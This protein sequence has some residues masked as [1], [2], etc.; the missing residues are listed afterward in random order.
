MIT[1]IREIVAHGSPAHQDE[2]VGYLQLRDYG[3]GKLPGVSTAIFRCLTENDNVEALAKR[4]DVVLL[5]I[6]A[7]FRNSTNAHRIFDEHVA[8]GDKSQ[9]NECAAT[10][11][12][13]FLGTDKNFLWRQILKGV[14]HADKNPPNLTLD[15]AATVMRLQHQG[16]GLHAAVGYVEIAVGAKLAE[17]QQFANVSMA[18]I[19]EEELVLNGK[20]HWMAVMETDDLEAAKFARF[21]GAAVVVIKNSNGQVQILTT[22]NLRLDMRDVVRILRSCEQWAKNERGVTDWKKLEQEGT[23]EEIPEWFLYREANNV[24]NGG[25]SRPDISATKL[26]LSSIVDAVKIGLEN[27]FE[28]HCK[29]RCQQG[30]CKSTL[31]NPCLWYKLGLLR[32]RKIRFQMKSKNPS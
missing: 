1:R 16:W 28:P 3:E 7:E 14:L 27:Q 30:D 21:M 20:Q 29:E 24:M 2:V 17:A 9:R 31:Q 13:K 32:C 23:I 26:T 4:K 19:Q 15:P 6:G 8:N 5:G 25:H 11:V 22:N 10:L 18:N 12:A